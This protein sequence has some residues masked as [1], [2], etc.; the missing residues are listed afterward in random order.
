MPHCPWEKVCCRF[1]PK[2]SL[3]WYAGDEKVPKRMTQNTNKKLEEDKWKTNLKSS[4]ALY[5]RN[6]ALLKTLIILVVIIC[7][8]R[9]LA[10]IC[11]HHFL[12]I[13]PFAI[14]HFVI[15]HLVTKVHGSFSCL[16]LTCNDYMSWCWFF[17]MVVQKAYIRISIIMMV[18]TY[19]DYD[20]DGN[21]NDDKKG[22]AHPFHLLLNGGH[23]EGFW[24]W[25]WW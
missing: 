6:K 8:H 14:I 11:V 19:K 16:M 4:F 20:D 9:N 3:W 7:D 10:V 24:W 25:W 1:M 17:I 2:A 15:I 5:Y 21:D 12:V 22:D 23:G 18:I 13:I